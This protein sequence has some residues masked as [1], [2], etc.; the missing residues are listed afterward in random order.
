MLTDRV[1][2]N[3]HKCLDHSLL[4]SVLLA[5]QI[6][7]EPVVEKNSPKEKSYIYRSL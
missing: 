1:I 2:S 5:V 6:H 7:M 3:D 4:P